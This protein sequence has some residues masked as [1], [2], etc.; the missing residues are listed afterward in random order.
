MQAYKLLDNLIYD[1]II[2]VNHFIDEDY[3]MVV[4]KK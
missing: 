3:I 4:M 2:A 1:K